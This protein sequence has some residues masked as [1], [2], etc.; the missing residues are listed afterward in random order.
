MELLE[1]GRSNIRVASYM[2]ELPPKK[3]LESK[4]R[5]AIESARDRLEAKENGKGR[6]KS[7]ARDD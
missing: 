1:L 2:T 7:E 6:T 3:V 5:I 4:L